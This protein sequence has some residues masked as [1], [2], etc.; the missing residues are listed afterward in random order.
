M[1]IP[2]IIHQT[3]KNINNDDLKN[4]VENI[5]EKNPNW[6]YI[7]YNNEDMETFI[8]NN[9]EYE[10][11]KSYNQINPKYG[12]ARADFFRYLLMYKLGGVYLDIKSNITKP[13]DIITKNQSYILSH[14][15]NRNLE[16][17][18]NWGLYYNDFLKGG[19]F[20]DDFKRGEFQQWQ[21][22]CIPEHPFLKQI[23]KKVMHKIQYYNPEKE[24]VGLMGVIR[25]TGPIVYTLGILNS[26]KQ[27][28]KNYSI[29]DT[30]L[31]A[32]FVYNNLLN[33]NHIQA[34]YD[35]ENKHYSE[36]NEPVILK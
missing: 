9:Y 26:I 16:E 31:K 17:H 6:D 25:T 30:H 18:A 20:L 14:W 34:I 5:K 11:L 15:D 27:G 29:F 13:L 22:S 36:L 7:F 21:I 33:K 28:E 24:G 4:N 3:A 10:V 32:G 8:K 12:A 2:K 23:I 19:H 1:T 35:K